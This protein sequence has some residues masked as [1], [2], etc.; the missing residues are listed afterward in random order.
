MHA[1]SVPHPIAF[2]KHIKSSVVAIGLLLLAQNS[3]AEL[4]QTDAERLC[5]QLKAGSVKC[6][7]EARA[8]LKTH[9][10]AS[11][12][13]KDYLKDKSL[14][15]Q[16]SREL[17][18]LMPEIESQLKAVPNDF[19]FVSVIIDSST[20]GNTAQHNL[21][22][23]QLEG[24]GDAALRT[25]A[26]GILSGKF[27]SMTANSANGFNFDANRSHVICFGMDEGQVKAASVFLPTLRTTMIAAIQ[28][29]KKTETAALKPPVAPTNFRITIAP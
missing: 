12:Y 21:R 11:E 7:E 15:S 27:G 9:V 22:S 18:K 5:K 17:E 10:G 20:D 4:S 14:Q 24:M 16:V 13:L 2:M 26:P 25:L 8:Q 29:L 1:E 3:L 19:A 23:L 28:D 6:F